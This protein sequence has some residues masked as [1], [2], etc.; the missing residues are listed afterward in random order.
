MRKT[1]LKSWVLSHPPSAVAPH[2]PKPRHW[3][4]GDRQLLPQTCFEALSANRLLLKTGRKF[5]PLSWDQPS[6]ITSSSSSPGC[7]KR[8]ALHLPAASSCT[9]PETGHQEQAEP[10]FWKPASGPSPKGAPLACVQALLV[11]SGGSHE[12]C[13]HLSVKGLQWG[14]WSGVGVL[15]NQHGVGVGP[16][17]CPAGAHCRQER[18]S[19]AERSALP[20]LVSPMHGAKI[21]CSDISPTC[22]SQLAGFSRTQPLWQGT[23][24]NP[25][26][27]LHHVNCY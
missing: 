3:A 18:N 24:P 23:R 25:E 12:A 22:S 14:P 9:A 10:R 20:S 8:F 17:C 26:A 13:M 15:Q 5:L 19:G 4:G 7:G 27:E 1:S 6:P 21:G 16:W 11:S 2:L